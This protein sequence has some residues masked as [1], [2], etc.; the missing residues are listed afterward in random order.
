M[1]EFMMTDNQALILSIHEGWHVYQQVLTKVIA[2]LDNDQL[3]LSAAPN[4]RSVGVIIAHIIGARARWFY[5]LMGEG[6]CC[7]SSRLC[8]EIFFYVQPVPFSCQADLTK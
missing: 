4:L 7:L 2:Q 5:M 1:N 3:T 8:D 6:G